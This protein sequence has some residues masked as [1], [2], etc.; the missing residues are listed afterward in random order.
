MKII[1]F[2][3][4]DGCAF[5]IR[6]SCHQ[7]VICGAMNIDHMHGNSAYTAVMEVWYV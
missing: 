3:N 2:T 5:T 1:L 6:S 7:P 4:M